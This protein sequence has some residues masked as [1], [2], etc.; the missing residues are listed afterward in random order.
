MAAITKVGGATFGITCT[1][2]EAKIYEEEAAVAKA[3]TARV[4]FVIVS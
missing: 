3:G 1:T 2:P 4:E